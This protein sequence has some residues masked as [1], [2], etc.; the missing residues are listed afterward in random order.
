MARALM[1]AGIVDVLVE[2]YGTG[3]VPRD[4]MAAVAILDFLH[5]RIEDQGRF[6]RLP[7]K[8]VLV[9]QYNVPYVRIDDDSM[10]APAVSLAIDG[11]QQTR[12]WADLRAAGITLTVVSLP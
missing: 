5:P 8:T 1:A 6:D 7:V 10:G 3:E 2:T 4:R 9:D 11:V 12:Y